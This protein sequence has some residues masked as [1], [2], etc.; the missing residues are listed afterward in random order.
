MTSWLLHLAVGSVGLAIAGALAGGLV[1]VWKR[2]PTLCYRVLCATVLGALALPVLQVAVQGLPGAAR[3]RHRVASLLAG[4]RA[5]LLAP[6]SEVE[7]GIVSSPPLPGIA[8]DPVLLEY[9]ALSLGEET[10]ARSPRGPREPLATPEPVAQGAPGDLRRLVGWGVVSIYSAGF[11]V[12]LARAFRRIVGTRRLLANARP[13]RDPEVL[14]A[15]SALPVATPLRREVDLLSSPEICVPMCSSFGRRAI[16]LPAARAAAPTEDV[17]RCILLH[18]LVHLER[19]DGWIMLAQEL[20][21]GLFWF[22]P[23]AARLSRQVDFFR[24]LSCDFKVARRMGRPGR[25]AAALVEYVDWMRRELLNP[26]TVRSTAL[27]RWTGTQGQLSRRI[28]MLLSSRSSSSSGLRAGFVSTGLALLPLVWGCQLAAA[29]AMEPQE[30]SSCEHAQAPTP[31]GAPSAPSAETPCAPPVETP[32]APYAPHVEAVPGEAAVAVF[33]P[34]PGTPHPS[35]APFALAVPSQEEPLPMIGVMLGTPDEEDLESI[36]RSPDEVLYVEDVLPDSLAERS[37]IEPGDVIVLVDGTPGSLENLNQ[38][39]RRLPGGRIV[40]QIS[41]DGESRE[42]ALQGEGLRARVME[43]LP[44]QPQVVFPRIQGGASQGR[45]KIERAREAIEKALRA[46]P[47]NQ[48]LRE[49]LE[50]LDEAIDVHSYAVPYV[51]GHPVQ[52][53]LAPEIRERVKDVRKH[54]EESRAHAE[55]RKWS[56]EGHAQ[57]RDREAELRE[58]REL[59]EL[60]RRELEELRARIDALRDE[61]EGERSLR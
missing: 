45:E 34:T 14:R 53:A 40:L 33:P 24:E 9:V 60:R 42:I 52:E 19:R 56:A 43:R 11:A 13:V 27:L 6:K 29:A 37:G 31:P 2:E 25:Y 18:E 12:C 46:D 59:L 15:W 26:T 7:L 44:M 17:L 58:L 32:L 16:L 5:A 30:S 55:K 36:G 57:P 8:A 41:R 3:L 23:S 35:P 49:A 10:P 21:C 54:A 39:K 51:F 48:A 22:H 4:D 61:R 38:A 47:D 50:A 20:L 1:R 28:E